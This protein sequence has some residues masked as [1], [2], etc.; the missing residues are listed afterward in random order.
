MK[1]KNKK[2]NEIDKT[3]AMFAAV[4]IAI[5][6]FIYFV[7]GI[8]IQGKTNYGW[9]SVIALYCS[10]IFGYRS[11]KVKGIINKITAI[12]WFLVFIITAFAYVSNLID[13]STIL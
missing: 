5:L 6:S 8:I 13:T 3:G 7:L 10:I 2:L 11:I 4:S 1:E 12:I 9:Y